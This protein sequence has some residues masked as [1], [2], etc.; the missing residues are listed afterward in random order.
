VVDVRVS[1]PPSSTAEG[2][3]AGFG[4]EGGYT[5]DLKPTEPAM[6]ISRLTAAQSTADLEHYSQL[7]GG[8]ETMSFVHY[9]ET[10]MRLTDWPQRS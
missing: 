2:E 5:A 8:E 6:T 10:D 7:A 1:E 4:V 3:E 9:G